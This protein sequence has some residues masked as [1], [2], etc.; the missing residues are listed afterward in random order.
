MAARWNRLQ[1]AYVTSVSVS[2]GS[3][4]CCTSLRSTFQVPLMPGVLSP[5]VYSTVW[6][7]ARLTST[8]RKSFSSRPR[9]N[10]GVE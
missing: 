9:M 10:T 7:T 2:T 4:A 5:T 6:P 3:T 1:V 8:A